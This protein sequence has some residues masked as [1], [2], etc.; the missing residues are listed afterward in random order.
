MCGGYPGAAPSARI[1]RSLDAKKK[2][3]EGETLKTVEELKSRLEA[4]HI[5]RLTTM[6]DGDVIV[7]RW[8]GGGGYGDVLD[9]D[10]ELVRNDVI[11]GLVSVTA[12]LDLYGAV[13]NPVTFEVDKRR[14]EN[15]RTKMR[16]ERLTARGH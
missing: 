15:K 14:T 3:N 7:L 9:R 11:N 12:A 5:N 1:A 4:L 16:K 2:M 6:R 13:I 10:T 8:S